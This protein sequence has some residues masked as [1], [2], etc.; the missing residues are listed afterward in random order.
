M[1]DGGSGSALVDGAPNGEGVVVYDQAGARVLR[2]DPAGRTT[3]LAGGPVNRIGTPER[4][5]SGDSTAQWGAD[6]R[7]VLPLDQVRLTFGG[8]MGRSV[9][10]AVLRD[11]QLLTTTREGV[12]RLGIATP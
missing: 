8:T 9:R 3:L 5:V 2:V 12:L 10:L 4:G 1:R 6:G 11:G 7:A